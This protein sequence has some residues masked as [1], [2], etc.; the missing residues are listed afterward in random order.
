MKQFIRT[1]VDATP[2]VDNVFAVVALAQEAKAKVGKENVIDATIG[3]LNDEAG[4]LVAFDSVFTHY[5]EIDNKVKA[6][7]ASSFSGNA[8]YKQ[9]V[10]KWVMQDVKLPLAH[11]VIATPGGSGA[12]STTINNILDSNDTL[13][14]PEIAWGSYKLMA[15]MSN[16]H[17]TTYSLFE[18][19]GFNVAN[20]KQICHEVMDK[21]GKVLAIINDPC[22]NPTGYSLTQDEWETVI[23]VVNELSEKGPVVLLNDIA[24]ID[25][26]YDF[27]ASRNYLNTFTN[28]NDNVMIVIAFSCSKT[29]TSYGLRCGASILLAKEEA[30]VR[31]VEIVMEKTARALWSNIPNAAMDNFVYTT[32]LGYEAFDKEKSYYVDLLKTRS[33]IF[34]Q[35]AKEVGLTHYPYREGFFVTLD[36]E[37]ST[38]LNTYHD[39][40][41]KENIFTVKVTKGIRV[42]LCSLSIEKTKGLAKRMKDI[43]ESIK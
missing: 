5:N 39:A 40:L 13:I 33:D 15:T 19:D 35:E 26:A 17:T 2:I 43:L 4:N 23:D 25:F 16:I 9:Q 14:I 12:V 36:I 30:S 37:D 22:H 20:F 24:Y 28:I 27:K 32:T 29:L 7:Y 18:G 10:Y 38:T 21:E 3:S 31:Q 42:G 11:R 6:K 41:M 8:D 34:T 1:H